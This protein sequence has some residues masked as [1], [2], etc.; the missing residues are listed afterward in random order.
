MPHAK[1][2]PK[3]Q[4]Y[5][6]HFGGDYRIAA[7]FGAAVVRSGKKKKKKMVKNQFSPKISRYGINEAGELEL[8][9]RRP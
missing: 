1:H 5:G 3:K 4:R 2:I 8:L 9:E 6:K 7:R